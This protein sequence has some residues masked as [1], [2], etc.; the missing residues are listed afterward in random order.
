MA[1]KIAPCKYC[2]VDVEWWE[3]GKPPRNP[4]TKEL[5]KCINRTTTT[6]STDSSKVNSNQSATTAVSNLQ[7]AISDINTSPD[8]V[9][10]EDKKNSERIQDWMLLID[11]QIRNVQR[12][13][14][15]SIRYN[16][17]TMMALHFLCDEMEK[18]KVIDNV[19]EAKKK[20]IFTDPI[21]EMEERLNKRNADPNTTN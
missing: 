11:E 8:D 10:R 9:V 2:G 19:D 7:S 20:R 3:Y 14:D 12:D 1:T 17:I 13:L 21:E 6:A 18:K 5:H 15:L 4:T 16:R